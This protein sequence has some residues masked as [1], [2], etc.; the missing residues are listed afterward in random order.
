MS[1]PWRCPDCGCLAVAWSRA[2][3]RGCTASVDPRTVRRCPTCGEDTQPDPTLPDNYTPWR[4]PTCPST[5][6]PR[7]GTTNQPKEYR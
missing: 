7:E 6:P 2:H 5:I 1:D 3:R 4:C